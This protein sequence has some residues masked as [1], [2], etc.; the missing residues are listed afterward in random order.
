VLLR[1]KLPQW[2]HI[3]SHRFSGVYGYCLSQVMSAVNAKREAM[4]RF[5]MLRA[6]ISDEELMSVDVQH[7]PEPL[8]ASIERHP[9]G[10]VEWRRREWSHDVRFF[11]LAWRR[12][13]VV[14]GLSSS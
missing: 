12:S 11:L 5:L 9:G 7:V 8:R 13:V 4:V 2:T 3:H 10:V 1:S 6:E 14:Q